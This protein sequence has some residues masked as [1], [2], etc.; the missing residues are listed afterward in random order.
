MNS[1]TYLWWLHNATFITSYH[2]DEPFG[3]ATN[4]PIMSRDCV[5]Q[6]IAL[7]NHRRDGSRV[8]FSPISYLFILFERARWRHYECLLYLL[9]DTIS[10]VTK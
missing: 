3:R 5:G 8:R 7:Y 1:E 10:H 2:K 9:L 6:V 4:W